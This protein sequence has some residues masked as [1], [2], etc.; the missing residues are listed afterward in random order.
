MRD[1]ETLHVEFCR[2][3]KALDWPPD[4]FGFAAYFAK[5]TGIYTVY[6]TKPDWVSGVGLQA[7]SAGADWRTSL[8]KRRPHPPSVRNAWKQV[9]TGAGTPVRQLLKKRTFVRALLFLL[10]SADEACAGVG[11]ADSD[12]ITLFELLAEM[13]LS[14]EGNLCKTLPTGAIRVL[15]KMHTPKPGLNVRSL[16]HH[17]ALC[18]AGEVK[19]E[20]AKVPLVVGRK[21]NSSFNVLLAPWPLEVESSSFRASSRS[22]NSGGQFGYVDYVAS[23]KANSKSVVSWLRAKLGLAKALGQHIDLVVFPECALSESQWK[24]VSRLCSQQGIAIVAGV[25]AR[26]S[27]GRGVNSVK[28]RLPLIFDELVQHKHHRWLIDEGQIK[29]YSFGGSLAADRSWWENIEIR[30]RTVQFL[31]IDG[32]LSL[33]VLICEDLAR[34]DPVAEVVR[35]VGP[36]LVIALLMDGPQINGRWASR[37]ASVLADDPGSSVLTLS[38]LGMVEKS[39]PLGTTRNRTIASW[40]DALG[41]Y[42]PIELD[43]GEEAVILNVQFRIGEEWTVDGRGDGEV[44]SF[45]V[46]CGTHSI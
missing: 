42:M 32:D 35:A 33:C 40:K 1:L 20:W 15:P 4:V 28:F 23:S 18:S 45:P 37:Y 14:R 44:A 46:V 3:D 22:S 26:G 8:N 31:S 10:A 2:V 21:R 24:A 25:H 39:R 12:E 27:E 13:Q 7:A 41:D 11:V 17:L 6:A 29:A 30:D 9:C 36:N 5:L 19:T 34:Q 43:A 16:S 38:S